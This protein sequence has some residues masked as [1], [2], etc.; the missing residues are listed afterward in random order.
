MD[1]S[2]ADQIVAALRGFDPNF[3]LIG[4]IPVGEFILCIRRLQDRVAELECT[5]AERQDD[6]ADAQRKRDE[7]IGANGYDMSRLGCGLAG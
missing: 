7:C 3:L 4:D 1:Q 5:G 6:E 2:D